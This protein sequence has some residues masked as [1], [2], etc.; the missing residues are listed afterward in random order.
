MLHKYSVWINLAVEFSHSV[1]D[2][3]TSNLLKISDR[4]YNVRLNLDGNVWVSELHYMTL[5]RQWEKLGDANGGASA[6]TKIWKMAAT[7]KVKLR[8]SCFLCLT[9]SYMRMPDFRQWFMRKCRLRKKEFRGK[10]NLIIDFCTQKE[11]KYLFL[12]TPATKN[13]ELKCELK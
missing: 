1:L 8:W 11:R 7:S 12:R 4:K 6:D 5:N 3:N 10:R 9:A 2:E 13:A